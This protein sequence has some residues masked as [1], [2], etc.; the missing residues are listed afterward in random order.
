MPA[1]SAAERPF[2]EELEAWLH[3]DGE[4]TLGALEDVFDERTFAVT[5]L[6]LMA[7][8]ALPIPTGGI[9]H[10]FEAATVLLA[11]E[12]VVGR[13]TVWLPESWQRRPLGRSVTEKAIPALIRVVRRCERFSRPRAAGLIDHPLGWRFLGLLIT[14]LTVS[15]ALAP[16]FSGLDT[17]PGMGVVLVALSI[18]LRDLVVAAIGLAIGAVGTVLTIAVGTAAVR[19]LR[20][21]F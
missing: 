4:K 20:D 18:L 3:D 19:A 10:V 8:T 14:A 21:L 16:P 12:M 2:S 17:L 5:I 9:T 1:T 7:P 13:R 11:A 15:A 6:L